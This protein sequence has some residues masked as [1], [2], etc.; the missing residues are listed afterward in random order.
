MFR[1]GFKDHFKKKEKS[2]IINWK[3]SLKLKYQIIIKGYL[4][5]N[6]ENFDDWSIKRTYNKCML[7]VKF[8]SE[9]A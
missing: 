8:G 1:R 9:C 7:N 6:L 4:I 2:F 5:H 3:F